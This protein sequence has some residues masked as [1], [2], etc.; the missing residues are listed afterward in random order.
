MVPQ[1]QSTKQA[2][3]LFLVNCPFPAL[4][5]VPRGSGSVGFHW[6]FTGE[7]VA[8]FSSGPCFFHLCFPPSGPRSPKLPVQAWGLWGGVK[9]GAS[10]HSW[11]LEYSRF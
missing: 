5:P 10:I 4:F 1:T 6:V 8:G 7:V 9:E 3:P 11:S 2:V